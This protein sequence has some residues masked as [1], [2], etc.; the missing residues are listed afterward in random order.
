VTSAW[1]S[2]DDWPTRCDVSAGMVSWPGG[3]WGT[4]CAVFSCGM[5]CSSELEWPGRSISGIT[6]M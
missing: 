3:G 4:E 6:L 2:S 5:A 1:A